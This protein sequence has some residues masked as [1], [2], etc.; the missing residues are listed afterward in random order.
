MRPHALHPGTIQ[1]KEAIKFCHL[2]TLETRPAIEIQTGAGDEGEVDDIDQIHEEVEEELLV[3]EET[4]RV[5]ASQGNE[6][7]SFANEAF[8]IKEAWKKSKVVFS[9]FTLLFLVEH[10]IFMVPLVDLKLA[11]TRR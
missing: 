3:D 7:Q 5:S 11:I 2:A 4:L 8:F 1:G 9:K 10:L 6:Q